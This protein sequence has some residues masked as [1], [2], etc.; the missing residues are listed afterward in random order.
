MFRNKS[1]TR[2]IANKVKKASEF[3]LDGLRQ[4]RVE[5]EPAFTDRWLSLIEYE[6]N[7]S[8]IGGVAWKAKT[9]TD[10]GRNSQESRY[11]ADFMGVFDLSVPGF[12]VE[13]GF[14]GQAKLVEPNDTFPAAESTRLKKQCEDM[15]NT[16]PCSYVFLFSRMSGILVVPAIAVLSARDCNP[17]ELTE[18][19]ITNF[20]VDHF[21]CFIGDRRISTATIKDIEILRSEF[22]AKSLLYIGGKSLYEDELI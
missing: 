19:S 4:N 21:E 3:A 9:L 22:G 11:G 17:H 10:R 8:S 6:L 15:L 13:K 14:M 16:S 20:F 2:K 5:H 12:S 7:G 18:K 1:F